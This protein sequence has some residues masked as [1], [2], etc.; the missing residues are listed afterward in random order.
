MALTLLLNRWATASRVRL[1]G[2]TIDHRFREESA[3]E[4]KVCAHRFQPRV[5]VLHC[6]AVSQ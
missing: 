1:V 3:A 6:S 5:G 2:I 4:A